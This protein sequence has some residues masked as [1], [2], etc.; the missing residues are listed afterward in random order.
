MELVLFLIKKKVNGFYVNVGALEDFV[1][2]LRVLVEKNHSFCV[3]FVDRNLLRWGGKQQEIATA[4]ENADILIPGGRGLARTLR[5]QH[6]VKAEKIN[7]EQL[8]EQFLQSAPL[9][10]ICFYGDKNRQLARLIK[11]YP[12]VNV[13]N[14]EPQ[15]LEA[16]LNGG[17][18]SLVVVCLPEREQM[19]WMDS[20]KGK[21]N[22]CM[23]GLGDGRRRW[24]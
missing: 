8:V 13:I 4:L 6:S 20:M 10:Q 14:P 17:G 22:A 21:I 23:L 2:S 19:V 1:R 5:W 7:R 24:F 12:E 18:F 16:L 11:K 9:D 3:Y 15:P